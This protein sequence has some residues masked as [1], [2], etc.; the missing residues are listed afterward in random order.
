MY[1]P[2]VIPHAELA[3]PEKYMKKFRGK[4]MPEKQYIKKNSSSHSKG[5]PESLNEYSVG[6][7]NSQEEC[8]AAFAAMINVLDDQVGEIIDK[9]LIF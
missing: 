3:A 8:H 1:Y 9:V 4:Y 7:Y 6:G 2:S 5:S